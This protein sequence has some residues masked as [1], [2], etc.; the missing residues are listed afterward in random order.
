[1][2]KDIET[3]N[4]NQLEVKNEISEMNN[5]L[6]GIQSRP[7][8]AEDQINDLEDKVE[9]KHPVRATKQKKA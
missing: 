3:M 4:K 9:K 6:E 5:T 7:H 2:K 8:E 1:M